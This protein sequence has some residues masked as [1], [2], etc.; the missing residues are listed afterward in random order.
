MTSSSNKVIIVGATSGIGAALAR[1]YIQQG[2]KVGLTGRRIQ[3]L[4]KL[5]E[6]NPG[7]VFFRSFD[8]RGDENIPQVNSLITEMGGIDLLIYNA[9]YGDPSVNLEWES[10]R[11][12]YETNVKG[13]IEIVN[14][15]FNYFLS[16]GHGHIAATSSL[17]SIRGN[18][19]APAY[20]ASKAFMSVYMEGL[21]MKARKMRKTNSQLRIWITDI[22]PGFVATKAAKGNGQ[23]WVAP[24]DKVARQI[25]SAIHSKK[26][27]V[28]VTRR[29]WI[30]AQ[31]MKWAPGWIYHRIA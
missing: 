24:V 25:H 27:R 14:Y 31:L 19:W 20:S 29:W 17:A 21:Y 4:E 8:V 1:I 15:I 12:T 5:K 23:F 9:G 2:W 26:W 30:I 11:T 7:Q 10:E 3:P 6:E 18:S 28:Y 16:Q 22:Q 13:F